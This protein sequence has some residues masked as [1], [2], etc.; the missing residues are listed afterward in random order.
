M[1]V[2]LIGTSVYGEVVAVYGR[3]RP[4]VARQGMASRGEAVWGADGCGLACL[5]Y[6]HLSKCKK[7]LTIFWI[8]AKQATQDQGIV[9][10]QVFAQRMIQ[11]DGVC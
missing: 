5:W 10:R 11:N 2:L 1:K 3:A 7:L 6:G 9:P 8:D 4:G